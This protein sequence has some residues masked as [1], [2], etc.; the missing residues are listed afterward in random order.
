MRITRPCD[1]LRELRERASHLIK[2]LRSEDPAPARRAAERLRQ[3]RSFGGRGV[4]E[5]LADRSIV[6][7]KHALAVVADEAGFASWAE[8]VHAYPTAGP[9]GRADV[10]AILDRAHGVFLNRWFA[11]HVTA[12]ASRAA[13]GGFLL[14][15]G[16]Q[17]VVCE[18]ELLESVG[19]DASDPDWERIGWDWVAPADASARERLAA[20]LVALGFDRAAMRREG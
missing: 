14:P 7:R 12:R 13:A 16:A 11:D 5:L 19:I 4:D 20:R 17:F 18:E 6:R 8:A 9:A 3:L 15:Y 1:A 10:A 2:D